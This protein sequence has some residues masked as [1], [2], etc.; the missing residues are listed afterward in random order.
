VGGEWKES[1]TLTAAAACLLFLL[2]ERPTAIHEGIPVEQHD[3]DDDGD[4][5]NDGDD[6]DGDDNDDGEGDDDNDNDDD[7]NDDDDDHPRA[8]AGCS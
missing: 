7:D 8:P 5:N 6:D 2:L 4:D 3:D 1:W